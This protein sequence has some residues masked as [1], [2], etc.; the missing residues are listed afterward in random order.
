[1]ETK[2]RGRRSSTYLR[3][4]T[5]QDEI[6]W[7]A[8]PGVIRQGRRRPKGWMRHL[9]S[10]GSLVPRSWQTKPSA[11][12][13]GYKTHARRGCVYARG[14]QKTRARRKAGRSTE[15]SLAIALVEIGLPSRWEKQVQQAS[16]I[17]GHADRNEHASSH[18]GA[19]I[20]VRRES[21]PMA[22]AARAPS[23]P[24]RAK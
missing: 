1:M 9:S 18:R 4:R 23:E 22:S 11:S 8:I 20:S 6:Q 10:A 13:R 16:G 21:P 5:A 7:G 12:T 3:S 19:L 15:R 2:E 14:R 24:P 17:E